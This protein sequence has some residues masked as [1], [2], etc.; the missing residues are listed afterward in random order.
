MNVQLWEQGG[1]TT[2]NRCCARQKL[3]PCV[4]LFLYPVCSQ[5]SG[6]FAADL[7]YH[8]AKTVRLKASEKLK[9]SVIFPVEQ[10]ILP[11]HE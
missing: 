2:A 1:V 7:L 10:T 6:L 9:S 8:L 5:F 11:G 4:V 3:A